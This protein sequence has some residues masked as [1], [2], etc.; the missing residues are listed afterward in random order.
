MQLENA[1]KKKYIGKMADKK[2]SIKKI[3]KISK[4]LIFKFSR[5]ASRQHGLISTNKR[6]TR[7]IDYHIL[8]S[9][10]NLDQKSKKYEKMI[11]NIFAEFFCT[12]LYK[13]III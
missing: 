7:H 4:I 6:L 12:V 2:I 10:N 13:N 1:E 5:R 11:L 9:N 3:L 8:R